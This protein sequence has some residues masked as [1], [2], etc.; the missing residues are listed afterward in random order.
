[1]PEIVDVAEIFSRTKP[2]LTGGLQSLVGDDGGIERGAVVE[3]NS[4]PS[5]SS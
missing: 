4:W 3:G 1:M 5:T 2:E